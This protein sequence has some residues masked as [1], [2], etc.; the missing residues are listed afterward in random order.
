MKLPY[1]LDPK[2][3][4]TAGEIIAEFHGIGGT[5]DADERQ[6]LAADIDRAIRAAESKSYLRGLD[7][8]AALADQASQAPTRDDAAMIAIGIRGL[9]VRGK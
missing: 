8:C 4:H 1:T 9:A 2:K 5:L 7:A 3:K 6:R